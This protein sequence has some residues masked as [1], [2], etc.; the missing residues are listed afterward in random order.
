MFVFLSVLNKKIMTTK[1]EIDINSSG[2]LDYFSREIFLG[3]FQTRKHVLKGNSWVSSSTD[4]VY[5]FYH[6]F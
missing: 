3:E 5:L 1:E 6:L 4:Y 2:E